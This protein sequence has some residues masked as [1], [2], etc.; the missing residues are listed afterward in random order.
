VGLI[1][2]ITS[3]AAP[4][5]LDDNDE[6]CAG[7]PLERVRTLD[8]DEL[9]LLR[10]QVS[11]QFSV[12]QF[13]SITGAVLFASLYLATV[14]FPIP[15][16]FW[17]LAASAGLLGIFVV[18]LICDP[19]SWLRRYKSVHADLDRGVIHRFREDK[20]GQTLEILPCSEIIYQSN[21]KSLKKWQRATV[22]VV[23]RTP[24]IA[25]IATEWLQPVNQGKVGRFFSGKRSLTS[26]ERDEIR[27]WASQVLDHRRRHA[28]SYVCWAAF[29]GWL[30]RW[31]NL[32]LFYAG[33]AI[34]GYTCSRMFG[35][36]KLCL[37]LK[38]DANFGSVIINRRATL[39]DGAL[40]PVGSTSEFLPSAQ[41]KWTEDGTPSEWR[42]QP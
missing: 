28:V 16:L 29:L 24:A 3:V 34:T 12:Q 9:G 39:L 40:V 22:A 36:V 5:C 30:S 23:A 32:D 19:G 14:L 35:E 25:S 1:D 26:S 7:L 31:G 38:R 33:L 17:L 6:W 21:K 13:T 4:R 15:I 2:A 11:A 37:A 41:M 42:K 20:T 8:S 10:E 18:W 27:H